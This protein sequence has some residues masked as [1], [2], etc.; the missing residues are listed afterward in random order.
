MWITTC[1][2]VSPA[3]KTG[4]NGNV[5]G[6]GNYQVNDFHCHPNCWERIK[7]IIRKLRKNAVFFFA[8]VSAV[9]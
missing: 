7:K 3:N 4:L 6:I 5:W 8:L 1:N 9:A 2:M